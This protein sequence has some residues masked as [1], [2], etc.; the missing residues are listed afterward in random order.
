MLYLNVHRPEKFYWLQKQELKKIKNP[1]LIVPGIFQTT[2]QGISRKLVVGCLFCTS[3]FVPRTS[4]FVPR[5]SHFVLRTHVFGAAASISSF[6]PSLYFS[7]FFTNNPA[8]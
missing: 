7:K 1:E 5:T 2:I 4:Y 3:Y 6:T 8:R